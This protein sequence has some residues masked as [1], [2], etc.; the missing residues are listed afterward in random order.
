MTG[1]VLSAVLP[2]ADVCL[3]RGVGVL[4]ESGALVVPLRKRSLERG[5]SAR[6]EEKDRRVL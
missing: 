5:P 1:A 3:L 2:L 4:R 6:T